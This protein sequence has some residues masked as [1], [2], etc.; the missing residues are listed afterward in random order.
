MDNSSLD[1][2]QL[3]QQIA[4]SY[5]DD[6][7]PP[8]AQPATPVGVAAPTN[9]TAPA[10]TFAP[11]A[12]AVAPLPTSFTMPTMPS[13]PAMPQAAMMP[14]VVPEERHENES[15]MVNE[16][17]P[18]MTPET[19]QPPMVEEV[20]PAMEDP[21]AAL[22]ALIET[23]PKY[24]PEAR[25]VSDDLADLT[26]MSTAISDST[27]NMTTLPAETVSV[28]QPAMSAPLAT[29]TTSSVVPSATVMKDVQ[30]EFTSAEAPVENSQSLE[31]QNIFTMLGIEGATEKEKEMFL[32]EL[33]QIIW[34][35]FLDNDVELLL[36]EEELVEFKKIGEKA[37]V[38]EEDRQGEMVE[39][40]E[41]LI[42]DLEEIMKEKALELKEEMFLERINQL[43]KEH[44][45]KPELLEQLDKAEQQRL[46][47]Q[48]QTATATLNAIAH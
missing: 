27:V 47:E 10:S 22:D 46:D 35:D 42:P 38:S 23:I 20:D 36:T 29:D 32:D 16:P 15:L 2:Q 18:I 39:F 31:D 6:Y 3:T 33:Q 17:A 1:P 25:P 43:K 28:A 11:A 24:T 9:M 7:M 48:W 8:V 34:E 14:P 5:V 21:L 26:A 13:M 19:V 12:P 45:E 40:L 41:K 30:D 44:A 4:A 37:D